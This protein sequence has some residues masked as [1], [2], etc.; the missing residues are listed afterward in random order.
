[1]CHPVDSGLAHDED[2]V[3]QDRR[4]AN[5]SLSFP[6]CTIFKLRSIWMDMNT[7]YRCVAASTAL[8]REIFGLN[9]RSPKHTEIGRSNRPP[10]NISY[11]NFVSPENLP[12]EPQHP[13][14]RKEESHG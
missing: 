12:S 7:R 13:D 2:G 11:S 3:V 4:V 9:D 5:S 1:M 6:Q 10:T 14:E 8:S